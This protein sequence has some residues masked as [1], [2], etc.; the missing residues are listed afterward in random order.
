MGD[1]YPANCAGRGG[2]VLSS[3]FSGFMEESLGDGVTTLSTISVVRMVEGD[4][5]A[6]LLTRRAGSG[7]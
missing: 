2:T 1:R 4:I 5:T 6:A 7:S 3:T